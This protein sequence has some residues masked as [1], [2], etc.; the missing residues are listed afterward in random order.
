MCSTSFAVW[1]GADNPTCVFTAASGDR[2]LFRTV[3]LFACAF[4]RAFAVASEPAPPP[5]PVQVPT[6]TRDEG[7][8]L[9]ELISGLPA[10]SNPC[11]AFFEGMCTPQRSMRDL[12]GEVL[13][14][15]LALFDSL[16][17]PRGDVF[18]V[19]YSFPSPGLFPRATIRCFMRFELENTVTSLWFLPDFASFS[20]CRPT[21]AVSIFFGR[22]CNFV[23]PW[24]ELL[25]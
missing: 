23:W 24:P 4:D 3:R 6:L 11:V 25:D 8:C 15:A 18:R 2:N 5:P 22:A 12:D 7:A 21:T 10:S 17:G 14:E 1:I 19:S 13:D 9:D 20:S 16:C